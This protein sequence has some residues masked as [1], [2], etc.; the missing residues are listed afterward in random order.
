MRPSS[1]S[2]HIA[3]RCGQA[4]NAV[5]E[6]H[7]RSASQSQRG[8]RYP[9]FNATPIRRAANLDMAESGSRTFRLP[10]ASREQATLRQE[11]ATQ[12]DD[13]RRSARRVLEVEELI[14][15]SNAQVVDLQETRDA[16]IE[17]IKELQ[18]RVDRADR[19]I[20]AMQASVSWR[21]T[22]PLRALKRRR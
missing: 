8:P 15:R 2:Y 1:W 20:A 7:Q 6:G 3:G 4:P 13:S 9:S 18:H 19:V 17:V 21:I 14:A 22:A 16:Q 5:P 11:A 12:R 10:E